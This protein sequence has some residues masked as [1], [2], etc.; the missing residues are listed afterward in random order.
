[1][2][3]IARIDVEGPFSPVIK[4]GMVVTTVAGIEPPLVGSEPTI[5]CAIITGPIG[6]GPMGPDEGIHMMVG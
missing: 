3:G 1:M 4:G 2:E 5:V 6:P